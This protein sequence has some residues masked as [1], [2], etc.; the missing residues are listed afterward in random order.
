MAHN[1]FLCKQI[2]AQKLNNPEF[3]FL[4]LFWLIINWELH[5]GQ[6]LQTL[7]Y[8]NKQLH[9]LEQM[10]DIFDLQRLLMRSLDEMCTSRI[11]PVSRRGILQL[12]S[13]SLVL[14]QI[15]KI[16][17]DTNSQE[18]NEENENLEILGPQEPVTRSGSVR[19]GSFRHHK[20]L[21]RHNQLGNRDGNNGGTDNDVSGR[22]NVTQQP[23][24]N[25]PDKLMRKLKFFFMGPHEKI[26]ARKRIPWKLLI[27][28]FK[29]AL[30][31]MDDSN[32]DGQMLVT[33]NSEFEELELDGHST[34]DG[35]K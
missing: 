32:K 2:P 7:V 24:N 19:S 17:N 23:T 26:M 6:T 10:H 28:I 29:I 20:H 5:P 4:Q 35:H 21:H 18:P 11:L 12:H 34:Y 9:N 30:I 1:I 16:A 15:S 33:L 22:E 13:M 25:R 27:Q 14:N 3:D 31:S 8:V